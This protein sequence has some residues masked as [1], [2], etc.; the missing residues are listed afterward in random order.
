MGYKYMCEKEKEFIKLVRGWL[1]ENWGRGGV[2]MYWLDKNISKGYRFKVEMRKDIVGKLRELIWNSG[3]E[4]VF[5]K[6]VIEE[7]YFKGKELGI[8]EID[9]CV[10]RIYFKC[11]ESKRREN[12]YE[13]DRE[14]LEELRRLMRRKSL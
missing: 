12:W 1:R 8:M 7:E 13:K 2:G 3:M 6:F 10:V 5:V 9:G 4:G 14:K 11:E